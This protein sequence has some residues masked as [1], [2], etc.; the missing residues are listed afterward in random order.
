MRRLPVPIREKRL[1]GIASLSD[2]A[3]VVPRHRKAIAPATG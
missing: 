3:M 2:V 1:S